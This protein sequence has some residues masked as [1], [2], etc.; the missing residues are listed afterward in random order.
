MT[1]AHVTVRAVRYARAVGLLVLSTVVA[2]SSNAQSLPPVYTDSAAIAA[3]RA[4]SA[5]LPYSAADVAFVAGMI[6]H[7]AQAI[8]MANWAPTHGAS[9]ALRTLCGRIINAQMDEI[10]RMQQWL[11]DRRQTIPSPP[12]TRPSGAGAANDMH[13]MHAMPGMAGM[14]DPMMP[15][16]LTAAQLDSLD[17]ARGKEFDRLFLVYMMQHHRGAVSMVKQL[18]STPGAGQDETIFK[19]ATDINVDQTTEIARMQRML[20]LL[21]IGIDVPP[22]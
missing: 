12:L 14:H 13:D 6:Q 21:T 4:D 5:R 11:A 19:M 7:H 22:P 20:V 1:V 9:D 17:R 16:M 8:V 10:H 2:R 18:F 15:G 3:A